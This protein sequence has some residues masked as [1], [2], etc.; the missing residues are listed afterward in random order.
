MGIFVT[1]GGLYRLFWSYQPPGIQRIKPLW[2]V[3]ARE[4]GLHCQKNMKL[5]A[6]RYLDPWNLLSQRIS[7]YPHN[8]CHPGIQDARLRRM[9]NLLRSLR[10]PPGGW[11]SEGFD[12]SGTTTPPLGSRGR[13]GSEQRGYAARTTQETATGGA[14]QSISIGRVIL[15]IP[16]I[17]ITRTTHPTGT[18]RPAPTT[19]TIWIIGIIDAIDTIGIEESRV[20]IVTMSPGFL[21]V[22]D[23]PIVI[24]TPILMSGTWRN[25]VIRVALDSP[26][27]RILPIVRVFLDALAL[28]PALA[29]A[30]MPV[31][32]DAWIPA[33]A[34]VVGPVPVILNIRTLPSYLVQSV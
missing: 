25:P 29:G 9:R 26:V 27:P 5:L 24:V 16:T 11:G 2:R 8:S 4:P 23:V 28:G 17:L 18:T 12:C 10:S 15:T 6:V 19:P 32:L 20:P 22:R 13:L 14:T 3:G 30:P 34:Q 33:P 21:N 1:A 31:A 7:E